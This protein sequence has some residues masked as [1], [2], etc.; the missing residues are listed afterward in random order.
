M[1]V[2]MLFEADSFAKNNEFDIKKLI[3]AIS[4]AVQQLAALDYF[5]VLPEKVKTNII[6][7]FNNRNYDQ[8]YSELRQHAV[9]FNGR[10][11]NYWCIIDATSAL[12]D[13]VSAYWPYMTQESRS[14][15]LLHGHAH[16]EEL[17]F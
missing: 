9:C 7:N 6:H 2:D 13:A 10:S 17:S 11:N 14:E 3:E 1:K 12:I 8:F 5:Y 4:V 16:L 15:R